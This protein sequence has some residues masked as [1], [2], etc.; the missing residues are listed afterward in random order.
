M[1]LDKNIHYQT[2]SVSAQVSERRN[3]KA[4]WNSPMYTSTDNTMLNYVQYIYCYLEVTCVQT[5]ILVL[6]CLLVFELIT[7]SYSR[8]NSQVCYKRPTVKTN[9][10][11]FRAKKAKNV[12]H[13]YK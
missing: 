3:S 1:T 6:L 7:I 10:K 4:V 9:T 12:S 11:P 13:Q 8:L 5:W 2:R